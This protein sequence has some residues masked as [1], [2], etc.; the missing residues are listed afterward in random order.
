[1]ARRASPRKTSTRR[2]AT[3]GTRMRA[4]V[5]D[6]IIGVALGL[7]GLLSIVALLS[8]G[9]SVLE[10]WRSVMNGLLGWGAILIPLAFFA[11]AA[12][13]WRRALARQLL[14]PG[15]GA[16]L[17]IVALLGIVDVGSGNGGSLGHALGTASTR[18]LGNAGGIIALLAIGA[19]GI[20]I[21]ANRTLQ[22]LARPA[23]DRRP[24][25]AFRPGAALPGGTA[26]NSEWRA[27]GVR[28]G[29]ASPAPSEPHSTDV[30]VKINMEQEPPARKLE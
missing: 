9:G 5:R 1:M 12:I 7:F 18:A 15:V 14:L 24:Q 21:A 2:E 27:T 29:P 16:L 10:W 26:T 4:E 13:V 22:E 3:P 11:T 20:V 23:I 28:T 8:S 30:P 17:V 6:H 19:I 25:F